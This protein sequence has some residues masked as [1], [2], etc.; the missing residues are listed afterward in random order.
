MAAINLAEACSRTF[1]G[2]ET[3]A[4]RFGWLRKGFL[5]ASEDSG[6][7][8]KADAPIALGV[9]KN[10]VSSIRYWMK[11]FK[12]TIEF[13]RGTNSRANIAVPTWEATWLLSEEGADPYLEDPASLWLLH[14]WLLSPTRYDLCA[15]PTWWVAFNKLPRA[16]FTDRD[17]RELVRWEVDRTDWASKPVDASIDKDIDCLTKMYAP[18]KA[19][20][21][22]SGG[23]FE[24][25]LDCPFRELRL[26]EW[27]PG[28]GSR[29]DGNRWRF[30]NA[31]VA[32]LPSEIAAF[33]CLDYANRYSA[34]T[35][36]VSL[37]RLANEP[38]GPG[39]VFRLSEP[40]IGA[41]LEEVAAKYKNIEVANTVGGRNLVIKKAPEDTAWKI[42]NAYYDRAPNRGPSREKWDEAIPGLQDELARR[43][44]ERVNPRM[45]TAQQNLLS[46]TSER[47]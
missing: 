28:K 21:G 47:V 32:T 45:K 44:R 35:A 4:P 20:K 25:L 15:A 38:G 29:T 36:T 22:G 3:F 5:A 42:L 26:I 18:R 30:T 7:F 37:A 33:A 27:I 46:K 11:A 24:D 17:L 9:G 23:S 16:Q 43:K 34:S 8:L 40:E 19:H 39:R 12:L 1:A 6:V 13:S 2:H 31:A 41:A 10:M 14:W